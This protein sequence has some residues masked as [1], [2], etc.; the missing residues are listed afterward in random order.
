VGGKPYSVGNAKMMASFGM[1][2]G[3]AQAIVAEYEARGRTVVL[4]SSATQ[5]IAVI[6]LADTP[7]DDVA[8]TV[9]ELDSLGISHQAMITGDNPRAAEAVAKSVGLREW[10]SSLLPDEKLDYVRQ[11][12]ARFGV[13]G[14]I[15]D[16]INDAP[17]LAASNVGIVM[18]AAGSDTAIETAD[19]ALMGDDLTRLPFLIR[20][21][22]RTAAIIRQNIA[23][24]LA[25]KL[26]L[27]IA[28]VTV[29][30]PL[31]LAVAG[32]MGVSLLVTLN[33]LRLRF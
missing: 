19:I 3:E 4:L 13:V 20:L 18:G 21:S 12:Q 17:A 16:G 24:S 28:A 23:F 22:R 15:G 8:A 30:V 31:W 9:S 25:T 29:G 5:P 7:R 26:A 10:A 33:A 27:V 14:M 11:A 32:D 1:P 6:A 2:L